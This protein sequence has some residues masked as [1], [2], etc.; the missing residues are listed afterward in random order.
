[1]GLKY[2]R[3]KE[4]KKRSEK[5]LEKSPYQSLGEPRRHPQVGGS[6]FGEPRRHPQGGK[7]VDLMSID[8]ISQ[9]YPKKKSVEL[10]SLDKKKIKFTVDSG[11][12]ETVCKKSDAADFPTIYGGS[13]S[14]TKYIMPNG[15]IV[16]NDGEKH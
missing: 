14:L 11:A 8:K 16:E 15:E 5:F 3:T 9:E 2:P 10:M 1:M 6:C 12:A 4:K 13:E 7:A